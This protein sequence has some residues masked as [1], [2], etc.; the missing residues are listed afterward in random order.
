MDFKV[1]KTVLGR[2]QR[3]RD[4]ALWTSSA[5]RLILDCDPRSKKVHRAV[6]E[7]IAASI[8]KLDAG[9]DLALPE[10]AAVTHQCLSIPIWLLCRRFA[11]AGAPNQE[12][13]ALLAT[14]PPAH[15]YL[16]AV[17]RKIGPEGYPVF[18][19]LHELRGRSAPL[20]PADRVAID[21]FLAQYGDQ[22]A[23]RYDGMNDLPSPRSLDA[24]TEQFRGDLDGTDLVLLY[25]L[26]VCADRIKGPSRFKTRSFLCSIFARLNIAQF[27]NGLPRAMAL[28]TAQQIKIGPL[29]KALQSSQS[30]SERFCLWLLGMPHAHRFLSKLIER[31]EIRLAPDDRLLEESNFTGSAHSLGVAHFFAEHET[32]LQLIVERLEGEACGNANSEY[33]ARQIRSWLTARK[34]HRMPNPVREGDKNAAEVASPATIW[35][36]LINAPCDNTLEIS[37]EI[38]RTSKNGAF[39]LAAKSIPIAFQMDEPA[40]VEHAML[41]QRLGFDGIVARILSQLHDPSAK[42]AILLGHAMAAHALPGDEL[43]I[44][45]SVAQGHAQPVIVA[46]V[47]KHLVDNLD[48][49]QAD[50]VIEELE[51]EHPDHVGVLRNRSRLYARRGELERA[52]AHAAVL[53]N[54]FPEDEEIRGDL[55]RYRLEAGQT[56]EIESAWR[57]PPGVRSQLSATRAAVGASLTARDTQ[58]AVTICQQVAEFSEDPADC[59]RLLNALFANGEFYAAAAYCEKLKLHFPGN[60]LFWKK[61][62]QV[63]ERL[64][65]HEVA[66]SNA[67]EWLALKPRDQSARAAIARALT[68]LDRCD[69]ALDW[70]ASCQDKADESIWVDAMRAFVH[71]KQGSADEAEA[72]LAQV[73][74]RCAVAME[75]YEQGQNRNSRDTYLLD[76]RHVQHPGLAAP[77]IYRHFNRCLEELRGGSVALVGNSPSLLERG[78]GSAIDEFG[79]I[80]R[81]N[82][83][84]T[85]GF[86]EDLGERTDYWYSSANRQASPDQYSIKGVKTVLMQPYS[87]HFP[88]IGPFTRGRFGFSLPE[89]TTGYLVPCVKML[90]E[91]IGYAFPTTGFR[92]IMIL[93][94]LVQSPFTA[95][96]F[97]F[98]ASEKMHYFDDDKNRL[99]VGEVHAIDFERD[100]VRMLGLHGRH[101]RFEE[102]I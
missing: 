87:Q 76:G 60:I 79:T 39:H 51:A 7:A 64:G 71:T 69:V 94:F 88:D 92:M 61:A 27:T 34:M 53:A 31:L 1:F 10:R 2:A 58:T 32:D 93:E 84:V 99:Q 45:R 49:M 46:Q 30:D 90:S 16:N 77:A 28:L 89:A 101:G 55:W 29:V 83:F 47:A 22:H 67:T 3:E 17:L 86:K 44:W 54:R 96:G 97:D 33:E 72:E 21:Q 24:I 80:V 37:S 62:A 82:D 50:A 38:L 91:C 57:G 81:L 63:A 20:G 36:T 4:I 56:P 11:L 23:R 85:R 68:Y 78:L 73:Y 40:L 19:Q 42:A 100:F 12:L 35:R 65:D 26:L 5:E 9:P 18:D 74:R 59:H 48:Y 102:R 66:L 95:F 52:V 43:A 6:L 14:I 70:L 8:A 98:F 41:L 13:L 25:E 15:S 75:A